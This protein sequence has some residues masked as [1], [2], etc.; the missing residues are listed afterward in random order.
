MKD[1]ARSGHKASQ[2]NAMRLAPDSRLFASRTRG[3]N[4]SCPS[5]IPFP[6]TAASMAIQI[7]G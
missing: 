3:A 6:A 4:T 2:Q 7:A 1:K 5:L